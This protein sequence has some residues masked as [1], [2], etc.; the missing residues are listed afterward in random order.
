MPIL[1]VTLLTF[2]IDTGE[3]PK[4]L[5]ITFFPIGKS[6]NPIIGFDPLPSRVN[7]ICKK[8]CSLEASLCCQPIAALAFKE[9]DG[10]ALGLAG[11]EDFCLHVCKLHPLLPSHQRLLVREVTSSVLGL[12]GVFPNA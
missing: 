6:S 1:R 2:E 11:R 3:L 7:A 8:L 12:L 10:P 9:V 4:L 5:S